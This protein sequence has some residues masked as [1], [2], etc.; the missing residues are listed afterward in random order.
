M[1]AFEKMT[2]MEVLIFC[3]MAVCSGVVIGIGGVSSLLANALLGE[4]GRLIGGCLFSLGI[5]AIVTYEMRLFTGMVADIPTL[6]LKNCWRLPVCFVC[7]SLGVAFVALIAY[8][9]PIG[10]I[11][12]AQGAAGIAAK[13]AAEDWAI[14]ALCSSTLCGALIT[15]SVKAPKFAPQKG[16]SATVGVIFPIIVFAFCGF[17]H[18]VANMLYFYYLGECSW[19]IVGYVALSVIGNV[20]GGVVL[21]TITLLKNK[22]NK[23]SSTKSDT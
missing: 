20:I 22:T 2:K 21:P 10:G 23:E 6:G 18:S 15:L 13:L 14:R 9:T 17:D 19:Q 1:K 3:L 12:S 16:L 5:Y 11:V 7:N 4:W 8:F